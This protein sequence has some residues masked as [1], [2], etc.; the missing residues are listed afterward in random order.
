MNDQGYDF[1]RYSRSVYHRAVET[2][3]GSLRQATKEG[4]VV[5]CGDKIV[6]RIFVKISTASADY[7]EQ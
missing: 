1:A 6:R 2:V 4:V 3:A 5:R 7:E